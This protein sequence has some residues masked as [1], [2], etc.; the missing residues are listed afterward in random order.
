MP[1][2]LEV[3]GYRVFFYSNENNEP[4]HVH[5]AKGG[6]AAKWWLKPGVREEYS[7]GFTP[8][9]RKRIGEIVRENSQLIKQKWNE[10]FG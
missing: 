2:I 6:A 1:T 8:K 10:Y 3:N 5:I 9:E 7:Y 4:I